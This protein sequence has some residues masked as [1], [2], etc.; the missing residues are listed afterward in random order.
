M[1][2]STVQAAPTA[3]ISLASFAETPNNAADVPLFWVPHRGAVEVMIVPL[4]PTAQ[5]E[6]E[7]VAVT[8]AKAT[9]V[10]VGSLPHVVAALLHDARQSM[11]VPAAPAAKTVLA[12]WAMTASRVLVVPEL[13][14]A[15]VA[16]ALLQLPVH[17]ATVPA[18]PTAQ[19]LLPPLADTAS[20]FGEP[21]NPVTVFLVHVGVAVHVAVHVNRT[22]LFPATTGFPL[23]ASTPLRLVP[24]GHAATDGVCA[25]QAVPL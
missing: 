18:A 1:K 3:Q 19:M 25:D 22:P 10:L 9:V 12:P 2:N 6:V 7:L 23:A 13:C 20:K 17:V 16:P 14:V 4:A 8:A 24:V 11:T 21:D 5:I 15:H